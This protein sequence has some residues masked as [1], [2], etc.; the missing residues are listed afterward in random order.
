MDSWI[1]RTTLRLLGSHGIERVLIRTL[2]NEGPEE[3]LLI[4]EE[5]S[6]SGKL[7]LCKQK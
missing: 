1:Q 5:F 4:T 6:G 3:T 7:D 2:I